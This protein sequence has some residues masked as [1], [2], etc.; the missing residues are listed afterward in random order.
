MVVQGQEHQAPTSY[1]CIWVKNIF[2]T[3]DHRLWASGPLTW[4]VGEPLRR[5]PTTGRAAPRQSLP[6]H[7]PLDG[8]GLSGGWRNV[9]P[10][11]LLEWPRLTKRGSNNNKADGHIQDTTMDSPSFR[12]RLR[13]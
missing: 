6:K 5:P 2:L 11:A 9:L 7:A 10:W 12:G 8:V 4:M 1:R 3:V 13:M